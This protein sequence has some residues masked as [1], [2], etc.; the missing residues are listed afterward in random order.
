MLNKLFFIFLV[1]INVSFSA[2]AAD[3]SQAKADQKTESAGPADS[4][5]GFQHLVFN[6]KQELE[7]NN[8]IC[9]LVDNFLG[10]IDWN[11]NYFVNDKGFVS[12]EIFQ[13][14]VKLVDV[15]ANEKNTCKGTW[16]EKYAKL[17]RLEDESYLH[18][19]AILQSG[20][21]PIE[22]DPKK[23][24]TSKP[25][26]TRFFKGPKEFSL[27]S[28][29]VILMSFLRPQLPFARWI[30]GEDKRYDSSGIIY[31]D[32]S[33]KTFMITMDY[34][35]GAVI[36]PFEEFMMIPQNYVSEF[37]IL[38]AREQ[39]IAQKAGK[40]IFD[41]ISSMTN[42]EKKN[43]YDNYYSLDDRKK[44]YPAELVFYAFDLAALNFF[45]ESVKTKLD[46]RPKSIAATLTRGAQKMYIFEEDYI[47]SGQFQIAGEWTLGMSTRTS[48]MSYTWKLIYEQDLEFIE[49]AVPIK[50]EV[51]EKLWPY[52]K[53]YL[54][55][56]AL[57]LAG[58]DKRYFYYDKPTEYFYFI[59]VQN[60][61]TKCFRELNI[62]DFV[63]H[64]KEK[65][66]WMTDKQTEEFFLK[67]MG[68]KQ[69]NKI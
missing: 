19:S 36:Q 37:T 24:Y 7:T 68:K 16:K 1:L 8:D 63:P 2:M 44:L 51:V 52:R 46:L 48:L 26:S 59:R 53:N 41:K 65:K 5:I 31:V 13:A 4:R 9:S 23:I 60:L 64:H 66:P 55:D 57:S 47:F 28:G 42:E 29:D 33:G 49:K 61:M 21:K 39:G 3:A 56:K 22:D 43:M 40:A 30:T 25:F 12:R 14:R 45:G 58:V 18:S 32:P 34:A 35:R 6:F 20:V 27:K 62:A 54:A 38:R 11:P 67:C 17:K 10:K 50:T 15:F 69:K